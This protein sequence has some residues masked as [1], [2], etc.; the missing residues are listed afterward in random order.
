M[1]KCLIN[2]KKAAIFLCITG[3]S[4]AIGSYFLLS[5]SLTP[6]A[7]KKPYD[8]KGVYLAM[9]DR[10]PIAKHDDIILDSKEIPMVKYSAYRGRGIAKPQYNPVMIAQ[11]GLQ[12]YSYY[13]SEKNNIYLKNAIKMA[14]WL[15]RNQNSKGLWLYQF[16][17]EVG[18][19]GQILRS[20]WPSAMAQGQAM[21]LL[22]RIFRTTGKAIYL[23]SAVK[24]MYQLNV[25]V[26][27]GGLK[28]VFQG[29]TFYEEYPTEKPSL[30][31]NG[32]MFT[33]VGLYYLM[34]LLQQTTD[35]N[36]AAEAALAEC[37][38]LFEKG[39]Q[40]LKHF[41]PY[42]DCKVISAYHLGHITNPPQR[43]CAH[44]SY[45][46]VHVGLLYALGSVCPDP[47]ILYYR[48]LWSKYNIRML[49][50]IVLS[51]IRAFL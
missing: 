23:D 44:V 10:K 45:H 34:S 16:D 36:E 32:F 12:Q 4:I 8:I 40:T 21:S 48:D 2:Y 14:D 27:D 47:T 38:L 24:A 9:L 3:F 1:H 50:S 20:P 30:V 37:T 33:L 35:G 22:T 13:I 39:I 46:K 25:P 17:W 28:A 6:D 7:Y 42:Y 51:Y 15:V 26:K 19:T 5:V 43:V 41:L 18:G 49:G 29:Q 11:H 31:L